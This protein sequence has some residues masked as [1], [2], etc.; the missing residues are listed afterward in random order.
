MANAVR[1]WSNTVQPLLVG[2]VAIPVERL[3]VRGDHHALSVEA[4]VEGF[5]AYSRTVAE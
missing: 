3:L 2:R 4:V 1:T 5:G